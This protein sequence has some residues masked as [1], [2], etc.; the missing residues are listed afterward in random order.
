MWPKIIFFTRYHKILKIFCST[1]WNLFKKLGNFLPPSMFMRGMGYTT[2]T[3]PS[4][5]WLASIPYIPFNIYAMKQCIVLLALMLIG[6]T[7]C[8][9]THGCVGKADHNKRV[10]AKRAHYRARHHHSHNSGW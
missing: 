7:S 4:F 10:A 8:M 6:F 2:G 9:S 3:P 1:I 5:Y